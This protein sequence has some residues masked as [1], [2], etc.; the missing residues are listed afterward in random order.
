MQHSYT[1]E[2]LPLIAQKI[3]QNY[4]PTAILFYGAMGVGKTTLIKSLCE[5]LGVKEAVSSPTFALVN[6][7]QGKMDCIYHFDFYRLENEEEVY[8]IG[9]EEY[10]EKPGWKFI[11]WPEKIASMLPSEALKLHL[12]LNDD[13]SRKITID[14]M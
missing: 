9:L 5:K 10:F 8:Q 4:Q 1:L 13:L 11:E 3:V 6:E 2:Q 12:V 7:Y 14:P